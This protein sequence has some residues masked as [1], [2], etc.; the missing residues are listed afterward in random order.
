LT[1]WAPTE[2]LTVA[3]AALSKAFVEYGT[4]AHGPSKQ[5]DTPRM[6]QNI[7]CHACAAVRI[8]L[9][10]NCS[11]LSTTLCTYTIQGGVAIMSRAC[12]TNHALEYMRSNR[13]S[14]AVRCHACSIVQPQQVAKQLCEAQKHADCR[15]AKQRPGHATRC[16]VPSQWHAMCAERGSG[17]PECIHVYRRYHVLPS[18]C[19]IQRKV[20]CLDQYCLVHWTLSCTS[21]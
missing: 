8:A 10:R 17:L 9:Q 4:G 14:R 11:Q 1:V 5:R 2:I 12:T 19:N 18:R 21:S 15:A 6:M 13:H 20:D 16:L 3:S 7:P